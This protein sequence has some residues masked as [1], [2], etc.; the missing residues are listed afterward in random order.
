MMEALYIYQ[1]GRT[2][3]LPLYRLPAKLREKNLN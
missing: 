1:A 3:R 2:F